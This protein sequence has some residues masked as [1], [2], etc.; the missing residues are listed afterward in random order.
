MLLDRTVGGDILLTFATPVL[1]RRVPGTETLNA[2]LRKVIL[3]REAA[4]PDLSARGR[5]RRSNLGGWRS[6]ADLWTWPEPEVAP[7]RSLIGQA[8]GHVL[9]L[10]NGMQPARLR[11]DGTFSAWVNV[12]RDGS[13][14][15]PH[16]HA[17]AAWS[18]VYY[19]STGAP[20]GDWPLNGAISFQDP[21]GAATGA[22]STGF[23]FG[24]PQTIQPEAGMVLVFPSWLTHWVH[25]FHGTGERISVAFN[26]ALRSLEFLPA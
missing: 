17:G 24:E 11:L 9:G 18:G 14:N 6:D 26:L 23:D 13:Y 7:L 4:R 16:S 2:A 21:R 10:A 8:T 15:A 19:V 5:A 3:A 22:L 12:N 25:P 20:E 1:V